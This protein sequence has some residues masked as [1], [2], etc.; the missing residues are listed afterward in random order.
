MS[1]ELGPSLLERVEEF[2]LRRV[3]F[4]RHGAYCVAYYVK[5]HEVT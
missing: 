1:H 2:A 5:G 4:L 3:G